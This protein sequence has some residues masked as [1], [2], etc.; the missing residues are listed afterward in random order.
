MTYESHGSG[1]ASPDINTGLPEMCESC[2]KG[3]CLDPCEDVFILLAFKLKK[4][5]DQLLEEEQ[6]I[7]NLRQD[8]E[9]KIRRLIFA[10]N[11]WTGPRLFFGV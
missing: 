2:P 5:V 10:S 6:R 7:R 1:P 11:E 8:K 4:E 9:K 3:D